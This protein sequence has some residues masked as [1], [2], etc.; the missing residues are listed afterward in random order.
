LLPRRAAGTL[1]GMTVPAQNIDLTIY[2]GA[3]FRQRF[4]WL[5]GGVPVDLTG[6]TAR[7]QVR[8]DADAPDVLLELTTENDGITLGDDEGTVDLFVSDED[9][10]AIDWDGGAWDLEIAHP[11]GDVTRLLMGSVVVSKE[12]TRV[13]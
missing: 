11:G 12:V 7:M 13:E 3:T 2:Q 9:T 5:A 4:R 6:C 8:E 1:P 10:A